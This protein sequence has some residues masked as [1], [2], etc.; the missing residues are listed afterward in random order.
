MATF[1]RTQRVESIHSHLRAPRTCPP[2]RYSR[3]QTSPAAWRWRPVDIDSP[4]RRSPHEEIPPSACEPSIIGARSV[5]QE[6]RTLNDVERRYGSKTQARSTLT[7]RAVR[8]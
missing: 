7:D 1:G 6:A 5:E 2:R 4:H 3:H 8:G